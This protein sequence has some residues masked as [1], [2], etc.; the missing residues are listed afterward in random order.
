MI[1]YI[2]HDYDWN[3]A[4]CQV[5][6]TIP[7]DTLPSISSPPSVWTRTRSRWARASVRAAPP[8]VL[9]VS[10]VSHLILFHPNKTVLSIPVPVLSIFCQVQLY[11]K[12]QT[13]NW[14]NTTQFRVGGTKCSCLVKTRILVN[15]PYTN[16]L[17]GP[18]SHKLNL[19]FL[20]WLQNN[21]VVIK[22]D[23]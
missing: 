18:W 8:E 3:V 23:S 14:G 9:V 13:W 5:N 10:M 20:G 12:T 6:I 7:D 15:S 17:G 2:A 22:L 21:F 4:I 11:S 16:I 19:T 1:E